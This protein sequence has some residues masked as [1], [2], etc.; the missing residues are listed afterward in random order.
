MSQIQSMCWND[1]DHRHV[2]AFQADV[3][4]Y[5]VRL[6]CR[7]QTDQEV[8]ERPQV[9]TGVTAIHVAALIRLYN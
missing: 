8:S 3:M 1:T 2:A 5:E 6:D 9:I 7:L 4:Q